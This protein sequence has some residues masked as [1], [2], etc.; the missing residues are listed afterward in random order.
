MPPTRIHHLNFVVHDLEEAMARFEDV[1]GLDPFEV[2]DYRQRGAQVARTRI[3]ESWLVLVSPYDPAS[4]PGR[5]LS[6]HG[7]GFFLLSLGYEDIVQQLGRLE[8]SDVELV[9]QS[10][11][12][13]I[14]DWRVA[15][16]GDVHGAKV[17]L[18]DDTKDATS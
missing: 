6:E 11:R 7:E 15:D 1:L 13:G 4:V 17:Q 9:D 16:I 12:D 2:I 14:L 3:G 18:T 8:A 5:Y 10:P